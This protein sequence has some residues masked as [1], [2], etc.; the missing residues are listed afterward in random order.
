MFKNNNFHIRK[1]S[2]VT[3]SN[4]FLFPKETHADVVP[5]RRAL[6]HYAGRHAVLVHGHIKV[7]VSLHHAASS[8][9]GLG[10]KP[11]T[12]EVLEEEVHMTIN[13]LCLT[14]NEHRFSLNGFKEA[15]FRVL[16]IK[17][18][19]EVDRHTL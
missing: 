6:G 3:H 14:K 2:R 8:Q 4:I 1:T 10:T 11:V 9:N 12:R 7:P 16:V 5:E 15:Q 18:S 19:T 17:D 13:G